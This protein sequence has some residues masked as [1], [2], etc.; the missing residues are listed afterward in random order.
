[1]LQRKDKKNL[2]YLEKR[3]KENGGKWLGFKT[4]KNNT[5]IV[6][7]RRN[8]RKY[9]YLIVDK[10]IGENKVVV[11][12]TYSK[13]KGVAIRFDNDSFSLEPGLKI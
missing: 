9:F 8:A 12:D 2:A 10:Y 4:G 5:I 1:M 13:E 6:R 7:I 3:L 11:Q